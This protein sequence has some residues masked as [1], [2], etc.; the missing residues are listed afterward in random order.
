MKG[1]DNM[2]G[3]Y[4]VIVSLLVVG[5]VLS[6]S[7]SSVQAAKKVFRASLSTANELHTVVGSNARGSSTVATDIDGTMRFTLFVR[8]LSG[9]VTGAHIHGPAT[10]SQNA[11][12]LGTLCG[13][14]PNPGLVASCAL[15][16]SGNLLIEGTIDGSVLQAWGISG[17]DFSNH[18]ED[19]LLYVN[20]HTQLNPAGE[21]RG[22][23]IQR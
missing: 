12:V 15:D 19:G 23:L 10:E 1:G 9:P 20:V 2:K 4:R 13:S 17:S 16:S 22:Q 14:G 6:V 18:L 21:T 3:L 7:F 5:L 8:G 11:P